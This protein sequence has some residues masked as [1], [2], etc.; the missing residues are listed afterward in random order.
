MTTTKMSDPRELFLHELGD[1]LYAEN[2]AR[3]GA[4]EAARRRRPTR[5]SRSGFEEHLE[6]T[7]QHVKN[8]EQAFEALGEQ[9]KAEK[10]PGIEGIKKEHD[11]FVSNESPVARRARLVPDRRRRTHRALRDRRLRRSRDDG[12]GDGRD[13]GRRAADR[14]PRAGEGGAREAADDRQA[15]RP[16]RS[17][18]NRV[19]T[20][21]RR[22]GRRA[23]SVTPFCDEPDEEETWPV[24]R[25]R[26][27]STSRSPTAYNQWTQFEEFPEF[28]EGVEQ[29]EQLD[30]THLHWVAEIGGK[31]GE[32]DAEI[33]EQH[34]DERVAWKASERAG[35]RGRRH[36]PPARTRARRV[37]ACRWTGSRTGSSRRSGRRSDRTVVG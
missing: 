1:V 35:E 21:S 16:G 5:S 30:D 33:T 32:W 4:S 22:A 31:R 10:C 20:L 8:V 14:E 18:D 7:R 37:Y 19:T 36:V 3:E 17:Q 2:D 26:S 25:S 12:R 13:R 34:P 11:E 24:S 27:R 15:A 23:R 28:M 29:V 9:A 6:E